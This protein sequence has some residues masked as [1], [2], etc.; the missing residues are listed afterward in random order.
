MATE[1]TESKK[2]TLNRLF[3]ENGLLDEDVHKHNHYTIIT[4]AGIEKIQAKNKV[5]VHY[6]SV[7]MERDFA[8]IKGTFSKEGVPD[9]ETFGSASKETSQNKYYPEMAEKRCLSRGVLKIC[10]FYELG[11]FGEDEADDFKPAPQVKPMPAPPAEPV[12]QVQPELAS[13]G[14]RDSLL[15]ALEGFKGLYSETDFARGK[16]SINALVADSAESFKKQLQTGILN[17]IKK[18]RA[19]LHHAASEAQLDLIDKMLL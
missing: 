8:V 3:K 2:E 17:R 1:K 11:V 5:T 13:Q 10:R 7:V 4:R 14:I 18:K 16:T 9:L 19:E 12:M 15:Q 6:E